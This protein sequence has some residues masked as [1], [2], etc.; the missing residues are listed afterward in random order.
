MFNPTE[1]FHFVSIKFC[2]HFF[3]FHFYYYES[4]PFRVFVIVSESYFRDDIGKA[5]KIKKTKFQCVCFRWNH[6]H[7]FS[8]EKYLH[9][10]KTVYFWPCLPLFQMRIVDAID[11]SK[12]HC[13]CD[14]FVWC[15]AFMHFATLWTEQLQRFFSPSA[16]IRGNGMQ[17]KAAQ[18]I[19]DLNGNTMKINANK[20]CMKNVLFDALSHPT[21]RTPH[22]VEWKISIFTLIK[23]INK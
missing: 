21:C 20:H 15:L 11:N 19:S 14:A 12:I 7:Q 10:G 17:R 18:S 2:F 5:K 4:A 3:F 9:S 22:I 8:V 13:C 1:P 6:A 16:L 23:S